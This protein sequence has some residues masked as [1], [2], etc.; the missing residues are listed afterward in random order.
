MRN[1]EIEYNVLFGPEKGKRGSQWFMECDPEIKRILSDK[2]L[3][4]KIITIV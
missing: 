4:A 3:E 2:R 1:F